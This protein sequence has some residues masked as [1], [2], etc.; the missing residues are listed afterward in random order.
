MK[1]RQDRRVS[2]R[3]NAQQDKKIAECRCD[4]V[5]L[6]ANVVA[7]EDS[8]CTDKIKKSG[9]SGCKVLRQGRMSVVVGRSMTVSRKKKNKGIRWAEEDENSAPDALPRERDAEIYNELCGLNTGSKRVSRKV[10]GPEA[11]RSQCRFS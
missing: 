1:S 4:V 11:L 6:E 9:C 2:E 7:G 3:V 8:R 10:T 5:C